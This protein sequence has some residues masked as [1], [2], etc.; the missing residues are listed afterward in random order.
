MFLVNSQKRLASRLTT[1]R[2]AAAARAKDQHIQWI[3]S[4]NKDEQ[5]L[6]E[7]NKIDPLVRPKEL[8]IRSSMEFEKTNRSSSL[9]SSRDIKQAGDATDAM[10]R[11]IVSPSFHGELAC[12]DFGSFG[13]ISA[14]HGDILSSVNEHSHI[15]VPLPPNL[16]PYR[17]LALE[18]LERGGDDLVRKMFTTARHMYA[19]HV[20][21]D[22]S[23]ADEDQATSPMTDERSRTREPP[24]G[25]PIGSVIPADKY[26]FVV[27]PHF[28]QGTNSDAN[29]RLRIA[30]K[31]IVKY[32]H[33]CE[34]PIHHIIIPHIGR[35]Q[36]GYDA[37]WSFEALAEEAIDELLQLDARDT[38]STS[39]IDITFMDNDMSVAE[40]FK[41][42]L[43]VLGDRWLPDRRSI[44]AP[45]YW[46][47][48]SHRLIV[49][50]ENS[51]LQTMRRRDKYK[52]KQYHGKLRN[53]GGK[54][55]RDT[56][57]PWIW[58]TQKVLEPPPLMVNERSGEIADKQLPARPYFFRG[59]SHT[60]YDTSNL[61]TGFPT[62]R[63][64]KS[65]QLVGVNR[66]PD[67][68]KIAKPRS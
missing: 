18:V 24:R 40:Q 25:I 66:Q 32:A 22:A 33:N 43:S 28:W 20:M 37:D 46:S 62:M 19:E 29:Q 51:E 11:D 44:T 31:S 65:G 34:Q 15:V 47:K 26:L 2:V 8:Q 9:K 13:K 27:V 12:I 52:F 45:Q 60:L 49:M 10:L 54:Y 21:P 55:F 61:K 7:I 57:Q 35:G 5:A 56:L 36:F 17:G 30:M 41:D 58:R 59:L 67:T 1:K 39:P 68:Q 38:V 16:T 3:R 53:L 48:Q 42:V 64:S 4:S 50:D 6:R 63:R 23:M 14:A